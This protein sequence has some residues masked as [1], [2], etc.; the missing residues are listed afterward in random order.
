MKEA[1]RS[2]PAFGCVGFFSLV[3]LLLLAL[4]TCLLLTA[5]PAKAADVTMVE[6]GSNPVYDPPVSADR[7]YYP[8]VLYDA[9]QFS[10]H[11]RSY[12]YKM[13]YGDVNGQWEA[14][15]YS[16]DGISWTNP[17]QTAGIGVNG[18]HAQVLYFPGGFSATGGTYYYKIW[19]W[20]APNMTYNIS[21]VHT[22]DSVDG[23]TFANDQALTQ[24]ATAQLVLDPDP[25]VGWNRGSY[26]PVSLLYNAAAT[27]TGANPFDYSFAMYYDGT[28]GGAE[29]IGLAYSSDGNHWYRYGSGPVLDLGHEGA[30]DGPLPGSTS[31]FDTMGTVIKGADGTWRMW[32]SGWQTSTPPPPT[33]AEATNYGI[34]YATSTDGI[35]WTKDSNN[36]LFYYSD[37]KPWR[38]SRTY[39]PSVLYSP[40]GFDGHGSAATYKMWFSGKA[41]ST[42]NY[43]IGYAASSPATVWVDTTYSPGS[44]GGHT[45]G[46][47]AFNTVQ[48]GV[49]GVAA[50]G[51]VIVYAGTYTESV[52]ISKHV[53]VTG[54]GAN[55][56]IINGGDPYTVIIGAT[57][58]NFSGFTVTNPNCTSGSDVSGIV[59]EPP[60]GS[61][62]NIYVYDNIIRDIGDPNTPCTSYGRV[63]INI[64]GPDGPV[65]VY[66]NEIY[67]V[68]HNGSV[69]DVWA[70]GFSIWGFSS[71]QPANNVDIH[72]NYIH[73][74]SC[75][76]S[77]AAGISTQAD[78]KGL[79]LRNNRIENTKDYGIETRGGSQDSTLIQGNQIDGTSSPGIATG[80]RCSDP[81][82]AT[83]SGNTVT[84]CQIG[85]L[86]E[87]HDPAWG[88]T[89]ASVQP[90][91]HLNGIFGNTT[92]GLQNNLTGSTDATKNWWGSVY[93]PWSTS[94]TA[95]DKIS[96]GATTTPWCTDSARTEIVSF[97][98]QVTP[99]VTAGLFAIPVDSTESSTPYVKAADQVIVEVTEGAAT[100]TVTVPTG[101]S[102]TRSGGGSFSTAD[103][104][105]AY[106]A[107]ADLSGFEPGTIVSA[108]LHWG[109]SGGTLDA[110]SPIIVRLYVGPGLE[111]KRLDI[112]R[113]VTGNSDWTGDGIDTVSPAVSGGYVTFEAS[114]T[115]YYAAKTSPRATGS[116]SY[117]AEG[118]T[119]PGF[120][121]YLCIGNP[122]TGE[123]T[124]TAT[125]LFKD[126]ST[127]AANY[128]VPAKSRVTV[129]VNS[130]VGTGREV[131]IQLQSTASNLVVE[132]S[133]YFDYARDGSVSWT[134]GHD[135]LGASAPAN[136]WYFAEGCTRAGF[137]QYVCVLNPGDTDAN[138]TFNFQTAQA[139][140][141]IVKTG[142]SVPAHSRGTFK[143][144]DIL[145][146]DFDNSLR[147]ESS[148]PVVAERPM[149]FDYAGVNNRDWTGGHCVMGAT[150][151]SKQYYFAEG[152]TGATSAGAGGEFDEW[153]TLQNPGSS[154]ITVDADYELVAGQGANVTRSYTVAPGKRYTVLVANEVGV[155]RDTSVRLTSS[156]EFLAERPMY[157]NYHS[158]WTGGHCV[159]GSTATGTN[160]FFAEGYTGPNFQ[161][162]LCLQNPGAVDASVEITYF[163]LDYGVKGPYTVTVPAGTRKTVYVNEQ[164]GPNLQLSAQVVSDQPLVVERPMYFN[165]NG[166]WTGGHDV[167]GRRN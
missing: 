146:P 66:H 123:E 161:E 28:T 87:E 31:A 97:P 115:S 50:G 4:G 17:D 55:T 82:A 15:T 162:W 24:D 58:V 47:D 35:N 139:D 98:S 163:T 79:K 154:P 165:Y 141:E 107:P 7:A 136:T 69:G 109:L 114:M 105:A 148:Q 118:Y 80:I 160:W 34:G 37:G 8:C 147:L 43:T 132:R 26:G 18:Y 84:A 78:V 36:P 143:V 75:P 155:N 145:G 140:S 122:N 113:S 133:M 101:V 134:G 76:E 112:L 129:N 57:D 6:Y 94:H 32:Y 5:V 30:W 157:F 14:V 144:N 16:N 150:A 83:V 130:E 11:G 104:V 90:I 81:F 71:S 120:Q 10:S 33:P 53:T 40:T 164:A 116:K 49:N 85:V 72:D 77:K 88:G 124:V 156:S 95:G 23:V 54:A 64:G 110:S 142:Y 158:A 19:Y 119:G 3:V 151:L 38:D 121:E 61:P 60:T 86:V 167:V 29:V 126:G 92:F 108:G 51:N 159:I 62:S 9:N 20:N 65:E 96:G 137:D 100:H 117:L 22:A 52:N 111:G 48:G 128:D 99:H 27:N 42:G 102:L 152:T 56:T 135:V 125:Y 91:V 25:G 106:V 70:N 21:D 89:F 45:Y 2:F 127:H 166:V 39:T 103:L 41:S 74:I 93:G 67:N 149:Y 12:Y 63:G 1:N 46:Y 44:A 59:I 13:W 153:L 68:K 131:S 73:D 138:L